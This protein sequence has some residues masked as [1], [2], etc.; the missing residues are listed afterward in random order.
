MANRRNSIKKIRADE[1]KRIQNHSMASNLRTR[2]RAFF[3]LCSKKKIDEAR[4]YG[5][6]LFS[7]IDKAVKRGALKENTA[8]RRKSR[9]SRELSLIQS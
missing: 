4:E 9:V 2:Y 6:G 7:S 1:R 8:N 3:D 5:K